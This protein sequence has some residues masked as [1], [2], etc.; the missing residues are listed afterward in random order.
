[1]IVCFLSLANAQEERI[2]GLR[3]G[4]DLSRLALYWVE[5][6]RKA[7]ELSADIEIKRNFFFTS[8]AGTQKYNLSDSLYRYTS[9]GPYL[10]VGLD[11]NILKNKAENQY[12]MVFG[13]LRYGY[14][15]LNQ[16]ADNIII[17]ENYWGEGDI[18]ELETSTIQAHW[19]EAAIGVRAELFK[20]VF[21]GWS[22]RWRVMLYQSK[23]PE[24]KPIYIPGYG[25]GEKKSLIGFNY[26]IYI[27]I[28]LGK[29]PE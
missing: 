18:T 19:I 16:S 25:R 26:Y 13:G 21:I 7:F 2:R 3:I 5:P 14:S 1:M 22:F 23:I 17:G 8:E 24:M 11:Y 12:E 27:S 20:Y 10:R 6:E 15:R 29:F 9:S 4:Y 28:P